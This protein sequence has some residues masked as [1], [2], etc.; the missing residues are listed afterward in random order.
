MIAV[1][2][3]ARLSRVKK[4]APPVSYALCQEPIISVLNKNLQA[5]WNNDL[6]VLACVKK[7]ECTR[8]VCLAFFA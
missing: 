4:N 7:K 3:N 1:R 5:L 2:A 8:K 6:R